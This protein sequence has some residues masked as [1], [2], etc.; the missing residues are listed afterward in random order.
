MTA[1]P[2]T[3]RRIVTPRPQHQRIPEE[4]AGS[5]GKAG[6]KRR[7][8]PAG[9]AGPRVRSETC[10]HLT[11]RRRSRSLA[12]VLR[13]P[14]RRRDL[15]PPPPSP[16]SS[17]PLTAPA[18]DL[19][20]PLPAPRPAQA[21]RRAACASLP[22]QEDGVGEAAPRLRAPAWSRGAGGGEVGVFG[23]SPQVQG[24]GDSCGPAERL[25]LG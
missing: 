7:M 1:N 22:S 6:R 2:R 20:A 25:G 5:E 8:L 10:T 13:S 9:L 12:P 3:W 14:S 24:R 18:A 4:D 11:P 17:P 23:A 19:S 21:A 15:L 16:P